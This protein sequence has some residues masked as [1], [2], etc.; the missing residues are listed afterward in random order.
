MGLTLLQGGEGILAD[1]AIAEILS[2]S[3]TATVTT[4]ESS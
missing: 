3:K 4:L 1:R 2:N